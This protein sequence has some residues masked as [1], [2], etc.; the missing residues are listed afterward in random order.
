[1]IF[2]SVDLERYHFKCRS[3]IDILFSPPYNP[4]LALY[5]RPS[6]KDIS[7]SMYFMYLRFLAVYYR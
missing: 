6:L 3:V 2:V 4:L 5:P 1:M 7:D